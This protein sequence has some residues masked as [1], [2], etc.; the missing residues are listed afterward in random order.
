MAEHDGQAEGVDLHDR[1]DGWQD[2]V[3]QVDKARRDHI[4][5]ILQN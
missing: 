2:F 4:S 3:D 1:W 5:K